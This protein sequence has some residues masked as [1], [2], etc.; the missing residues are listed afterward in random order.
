M[1]LHIVSNRQASLDTQH[2]PIVLYDSEAEL[3]GSKEVLLAM[4]S[5]LTCGCHTHT[6]D[7]LQGNTVRLKRELDSEF[8]P[9]AIL[10]TDEEGKSIGRMQRKQTE[11]LA[12]LLDG[13][14]GKWCRFGITRVHAVLLGPLVRN[15]PSHTP[16]QISIFGLDQRKAAPLKQFLIDCGL[17]LC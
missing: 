13:V 4:V 15:F 2:A 3:D 7:P 9:H 8:D 12:P 1:S 17:T 5:V 14:Q 11:A 16:I 6:S 10:V